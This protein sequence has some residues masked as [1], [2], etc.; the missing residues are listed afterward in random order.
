MSPRQV[1]RQD[2][3]STGGYDAYYQRNQKS[4][5]SWGWRTILKLIGLGILAV[6]VLVGLGWAFQVKNVVV[7]G[8][9]DTA[10]VE[11]TARQ[12]LHSHLLWRNLL[13]LPAPQLTTAIT[14][15]QDEHI[16]EVKVTKNWFGQGI[17]ISAVERGPSLQWRSGGALYAVD[18]TGRIIKQLDGQSSAPL[19]VDTSNVAVKVNDQVVSRQFVDFVLSV[20]KG[21]TQQAGLTAT[22]WRINDT[23]SE[24]FVDTSGG[25]YVRFDTTRSADEQLQ[26]L[27]SVLGDAKAKNAGPHAYV[28]VRIPYK[29]YYR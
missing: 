18:Q 15:A 28:D 21:L 16:T 12:Q 2:S 25:F 1:R 29:A 13:L 27:K 10:A 14:K 24:L 4:A 17:H 26:E 22:A 3:S 6:V 8:S 11:Q 19:V 5:Q 23:T 7:S 9:I 20:T